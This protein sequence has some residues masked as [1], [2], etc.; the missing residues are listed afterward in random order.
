M[1]QNANAAVLEAR[2]VLGSPR[3]YAAKSS[4]C[5]QS[6]NTARPAP[7]VLNVGVQDYLTRDDGFARTIWV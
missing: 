6:E 2:R 7:P 3:D 4:T 5:A 1:F